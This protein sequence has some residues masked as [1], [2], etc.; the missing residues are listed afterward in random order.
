MGREAAERLGVH[1]VR[2]VHDAAHPPLPAATFDRVLVDAPCCGIGSARRR[3]ELLWRVSEGDCRRAG[4]TAARDRDL[5]CGAP[6]AGRPARLLRLHVPTA[7]TDA[8][9][10]VLVERTG[11][12]PIATPGPGGEALRHRVWPHRHGAD[13]MFIAVFERSA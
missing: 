13:G 11:L 5:G 12:R 8:V 6:A 3:P 10:D 9:A 2:V 7:E 4:S 1:P